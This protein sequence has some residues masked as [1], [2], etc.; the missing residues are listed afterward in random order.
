MKKT[1]L[2]FKTAHNYVRDVICMVLKVEDVFYPV[3]KFRD[4]N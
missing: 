2:L 3:L 4:K 1:K